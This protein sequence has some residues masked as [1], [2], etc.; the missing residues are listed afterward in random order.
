[1]RAIHDKYYDKGA[2]F[3]MPDGIVE[4]A[5]C[6]DSGLLPGKYCKKDPRGSRIYTE[7][8]AEGTVP[9]ETCEH[10][11][12]VEVCKVSGLLPSDNCQEIVK[13]VF[14]KKDNKLR[15][16][17]LKYTAPTKKCDKCA[18]IEADNKKK[19]QAVSELI[20][21]LP[22]EESLTLADESKVNNASSKYNALSAAAK[23]F[24]SEAN[25]TKLD[26]AIKKIQELKDDD[27]DDENSDP[28]DP[29][30]TP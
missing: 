18:K 9:T 16:A 26:N 8:F 27:E 11:E 10:H 30:E 23:K 6:R 19:A 25:K 4:V 22:S 17:D 29:P 2:N 12:E 14:L 28:G 15:A 1:M 24:V 7:Y 13:K 20:E 3:K 21:A 5:V